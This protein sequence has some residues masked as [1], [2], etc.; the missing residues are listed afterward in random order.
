MILLWD[1]IKRF[2]MET[3][4]ANNMVWAESAWQRAKQL[5]TDIKSRIE[6]VDA[7]HRA[8]MTRAREDADRVGAA[9]IEE[10]EDH[11]L[12]CYATI[13]EMLNWQGMKSEAGDQLLSELLI[14]M[15]GDVHKKLVG[16]K[17]AEKANDPGMHPGP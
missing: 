16:E 7:E 9:R 10:L 17:K 1:L 12:M 5:E 8:D 15:P 3:E 11:G 2:M 13:H 6:E 4:R 14:R